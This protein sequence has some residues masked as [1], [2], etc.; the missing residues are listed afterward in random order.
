[1]ELQQVMDYWTLTLAA[2]WIKREHHDVKEQCSVL[3]Q[4][5][6][7]W[8]RLSFVRNERPSVVVNLEPLKTAPSVAMR[9]MDLNSRQ[10]E[11]WMKM[12]L[13]TVYEGW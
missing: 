8:G 13:T 3:G 9:G 2:D 1:M 7:G 10:L 4:I 6:F 12:L 11:M 5:Y